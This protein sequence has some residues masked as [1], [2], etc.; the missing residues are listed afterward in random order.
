MKKDLNRMLKAI[1][2]NG[3]LEDRSE[4][5]AEMLRDMYSINMMEA[6]ELRD[7]IAQEM[8]APEIRQFMKEDADQEAQAHEAFDKQFKGDRSASIKIMAAD[9]AKKMRRGK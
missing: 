4:Y 5:D 7:M 8:A 6:T 9:L 1:V 2:K 3:L